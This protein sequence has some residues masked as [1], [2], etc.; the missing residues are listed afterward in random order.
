[1][2]ILLLSTIL[3]PVSA[4]LIVLVFLCGAYLWLIALA[5]IRTPHRN[6]ET[7]P[8]NHFAI[9]IP[10]HNEESVIEATIS[11][12]K[13]LDYP[14]NFYDIYIVADHCTDHTAEFARTQGIVCYERQ[15]GERGSKGA[16]LRW[17]F[18]KIFAGSMAYDAV[19]ILD[20]D[21]QVDSGFLKAMNARLNLGADVIQGKHVISNPRKG[22]FPTLTWAMMTVD[23]RYSNQGRANLGLSAKHM[24]DSICFRSYVLKEMGWGEGLTEDYE[25]RLRLLLSGIMIDYEPW[26]IGYGQA[27]VT[28]KD[29]LSQ[30]LRWAKGNADAGKRYIRQLFR[31]GLLQKDWRKL[32]GA[33][34]VNMPSYSTLAL[35][36]VLFFFIHLLFLHQTWL[37]LTFGWG[38]FVILFFLYPMFG[39]AL[40]HAPGWAYLV[41]LSGPIFMLWRTWL[42]IIARLRPDEI[43]W[44]RT[45]HRG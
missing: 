23:N 26:A 27:P 16:A 42:H 36:S 45:P 10:A 31:D 13:K 37:W 40:E 15:E 25:F 1:M 17:L 19:I 29:A 28:W 8:N 11:S 43:T 21:T 30:R 14:R 2:D 5:G 35:T 7:S 4:A 24:G 18:P 32:D 3:N 41:I 44:V 12:L 38:L 39:L 6:G 20:A 33:L 34:S 22:W 9:A